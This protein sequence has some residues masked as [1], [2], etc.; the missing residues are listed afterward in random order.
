MNKAGHSSGTTMIFQR[1]VPLFEGSFDNPKGCSLWC[2]SMKFSFL[3]FLLHPAALICKYSDFL[4]QQG[5]RCDSNIQTGPCT[6]EEM[7]DLNPPSSK[8]PASVWITR[9]SQTTSLPGGSLNKGLKAPTG[10]ASNTNS[11]TKLTFENLG[12]F[13]M[14]NGAA[15]L[16]HPQILAKI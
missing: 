10:Q 14:A 8:E 1:S 7:E 6:K 12:G 16:S 2:T 3:L 11:L 13:F 9:Q 4:Y 15:Q 5:L